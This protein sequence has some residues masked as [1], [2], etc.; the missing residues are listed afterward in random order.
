MG[1]GSVIHG[2]HEEQNI[3]RMGGLRKLMPITFATYAVGMLALCGFPLFFSGFWSKD[4]ILHAASDVERLAG[5]VLSGRYRRAA[6]GLL[7]DA[8]GVLRLL[9]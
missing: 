4:A 6:D 5:S 9:R 2:C 7:Y 8:A 1:A 3:R